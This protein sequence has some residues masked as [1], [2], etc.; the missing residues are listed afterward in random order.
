MKRSPLLILAS[1]L[2][3]SVISSGS[4][5]PKVQ[6]DK[7]NP[8]LE[9]A[10]MEIEQAIIEADRNKLKVELKIDKNLSA[11]ESFSIDVDNANKIVVTGA[12]PTGAMYGGLEVA[13]LLKLGLTIENIS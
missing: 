9:F 4:F 5:L 12:D 8:Q 11:P 1:L 6:Y 13:E 2:L 7:K 3:V 10:A